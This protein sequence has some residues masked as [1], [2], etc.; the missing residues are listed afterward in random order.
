M[1]LTDSIDPGLIAPFLVFS[2]P[3]LYFA[4]RIFVPASNNSKNKKYDPKTGI[5]RGAPGFATGVKRVAIP[6]ELAARIRAGEEVSA[7]EV[8][9]ALD[10]EKERMRK[11]EEEEERLKNGGR[12]LPAGVDSEWLPQG[13][14][15]GSSKAKKRK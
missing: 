6:P 8:T 13:A 4:Y 12:K 3:V 11:E 1:G 5:G 14:L 2:V 10:A 15:G 9:A 7:E